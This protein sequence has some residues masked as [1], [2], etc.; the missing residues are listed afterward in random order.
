[1]H[2]MR[3]FWFAFCRGFVYLLFLTLL[4]SV[5]LWLQNMSTQCLALKPRHCRETE[6]H[7]IPLSKRVG[8]KASHVQ[9]VDG[10]TG[11]GCTD[12]I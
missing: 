11:P 2:I 3:I 10:G 12:Q 1:M 4:L 5:M 6:Q 9:R 8:Q 7:R